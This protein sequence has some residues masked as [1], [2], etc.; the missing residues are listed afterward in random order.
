M[1]TWGFV[2]FRF[3]TGHRFDIVPDVVTHVTQPSPSGKSTRGYL[4]MYIKTY[5]YIY[6]CKG[7]Y[8]LYYIYM[9]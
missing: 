7:I 4:Y 8:K 9:T 5:I 3:F 1:G 2:G 6:I